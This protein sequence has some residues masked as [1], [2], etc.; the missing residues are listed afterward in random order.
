MALFIKY[1]HGEGSWH[2]HERHPSSRY[3]DVSTV[4]EIQ[5]DGDELV[6]LKTRFNNLPMRKDRAVVTWYGE[7]A[8]FIY[9]NL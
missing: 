8:K 6:H 2:V 7:M 4:L 1:Q 9:S 3:G 5:A